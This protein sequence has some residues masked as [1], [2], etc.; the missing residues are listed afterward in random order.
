M[1][2]A[3]R[4]SSEL[5]GVIARNAEGETM[6]GP[7]QPLPERWVPQ[8]L[9][10]LRIVTAFL[11][12]AHGTQKLFGFP[13]SQPGTPV[14]LGSLIGMAG[15]LETFGGALL[16]VGLLSRPIAFLLSGEM[17]VAYFL[18]HSPQGFWPALNGGELAVL[19][20]FLFLFLAAA[21]PGVWSL[22]AVLRRARTRQ[23]PTP[24]DLRWRTSH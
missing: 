15:I 6:I 19:Y 20:C 3:V 17:A 2:R 1:K 23:P 7:L 18:R 24:S 22:D 11:F 4:V 8:L 16:L 21:G 14:E 9:S 12:I 10:V 5:S 13:T